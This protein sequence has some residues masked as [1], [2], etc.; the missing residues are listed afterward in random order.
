MA[1]VFARLKLPRP[2][3][4][5][6]GAGAASSSAAAAAAGGRSARGPQQ[7]GGA[8]RGHRQ[9]TPAAQQQQQ[10]PAVGGLA[11]GSQL[12]DYGVHAFLVPIRDAEGHLMPGVEIRDCGYKVRQWRGS[13][14]GDSW[15]A[16]V[17]RAAAL[18]AAIA[19]GGG[20]GRSML[21]IA[22]AAQL[23]A[24]MGPSLSPP[25]RWAS[26]AWTTAPSA[27]RT[28]ACRAAT[29]STASAAWTR[30]AS[31]RRPSPA[32]RAGARC[33]V[34]GGASCE[35]RGPALRP[36]TPGAGAARLRPRWASELACG[37]PCC[38]PHRCPPAVA[39]AHRFA[40]TLG[41]LTGGRV[42]LVSG[43]VGVSKLAL[44]IAIRYCAQRQQFGPPGSP[45]IAVL[46]YQV[47][48][49]RAGARARV[50]GKSR[51]RLRAASP[52]P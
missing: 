49:A 15:A 33:I 51:A 43:S 16:G 28:C 25:C 37:L 23:H 20:N 4:Q 47:R 39:R 41:E 5:G 6:T 42:G 44:T 40:A 36:P 17:A 8:S 21:T 34:G 24:P 12:V 31:T 13:G 26:T 10:Q 22:A 14:G 2:S 19:R 35:G 46:D 52:P 45:E 1:T 7:Q 50:R 48:R 9:G 38:A 27:S 3:A 30:A 32:R 11:G 18:S 29:C